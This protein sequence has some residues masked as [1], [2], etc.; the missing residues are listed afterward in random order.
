LGKVNTPG[1]VPVTVAGARIL[2]TIALA[3]GTTGETYQS[4]VTLRRGNTVASANLEDLFDE[5]SNNVPVR[6]GD[7]VLVSDVTK[8]FTVFGATNERQE[9]PFDARRVTLAEGLARAGGLDDELAD[10][11]GVF[12]FRFEPDFIAKALDERAV[13]TAEGSLVPTI[14][15]LN[16]KDPK[17]FFLM[18][19][20]DLRDED[21][22]YVA[23]HPSAQFGKFLEIISPVISTAVTVA[24]LTA[25]FTE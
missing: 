21:I 4:Q 14:Y 19:L 18:P 24:T 15:Q 11:R 20:F 6:S 13:T 7:V 5:P 23:N 12:V 10:A 22:I 8:S 1:A 17:A 25:R 2:D 16:L 9:F 3:G